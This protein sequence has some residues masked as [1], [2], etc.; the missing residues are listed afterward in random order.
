MRQIHAEFFSKLNVFQKPEGLVPKFLGFQDRLDIFM[1][2]WIARI[3]LKGGVLIK[4]QALFFICQVTIRGGTWPPGPLA[5]IPPSSPI[6]RPPPRP[7]LS[8]TAIPSPTPLPSPL[9]PLPRPPPSAPL[10]PRPRPS[11]PSPSLSRHRSGPRRPAPSRPP[12]SRRWRRPPATPPAR[13]P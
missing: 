5:S 7:T 1:R 8:P 2:W 12:G 11:T 10:R 4:T 9:C 6:P 13:L 3:H